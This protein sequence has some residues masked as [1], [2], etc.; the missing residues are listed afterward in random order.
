MKKYLL[1][2]LLSSC[3]TMFIST[4]Q[5]NDKELFFDFEKE[6]VPEGKIMLQNDTENKY[7]I[8]FFDTSH[9]QIWSIQIS[10]G[11]K[12]ELPEIIRTSRWI[13]VRQNG[14]IIYDAEGPEPGDLLILRMAVPAQII[15]VR[16][17]RWAYIEE[18]IKVVNGVVYPLRVSL[19]GSENQEIFITHCAAGETR[20]IALEDLGGHSFDDV[21]H[22]EFEQVKFQL[23]VSASTVL[24]GY[25]YIITSSLTRED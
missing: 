7:G 16:V 19:I 6:V 8:Y 17:S 15:S 3:S 25:E 12:V 11:Q 20:H 5:V 21:D 22:I 4:E 9:E 1:L 23:S 2:L 18:G 13:Q 10:P 24:P 14:E